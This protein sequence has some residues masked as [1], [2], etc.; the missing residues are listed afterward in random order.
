MKTARKGARMFGKIAGAWIGSKVAGR[1]QGMKGALIGAGAAAVARRG[2][3]PLAMAA[4]A[5]YGAKKLWDWNR[6]RD[7]RPG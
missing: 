2:L 6:G 1:N 3:G 5:A 7:R 4:A